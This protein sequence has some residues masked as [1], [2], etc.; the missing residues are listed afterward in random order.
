MY[1]FC[2]VLSKKKKKQN[3]VYTKWFIFNSNQL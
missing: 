1:H 3:Y 2:T